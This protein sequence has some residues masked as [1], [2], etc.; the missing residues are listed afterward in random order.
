MVSTTPSGSKRTSSTRRAASSERRRAAAQPT[1]SSARIAPAARVRGDRREHR[2]Q[3]LQFER[4]FLRL[5][6]PELAAQAAHDGPHD[7]VLGGAD[8]AR[9]AV[10]HGDRGQLARD[11]R[12]PAAAAGQIRDIQGHGFGLSRL[13]AAPDA[14]RC[15]N[16]KRMRLN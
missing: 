16:A 9:G 4:G 14:R 15:E 1:S 11:R 8:L 6:D 2:A 7:V 5:G 12:R 10:E 13:A 3:R